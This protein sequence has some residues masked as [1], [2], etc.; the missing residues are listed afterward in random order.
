MPPNTQKRGNIYYFRRKVPVDLRQHYDKPVLLVSLGTPDYATAKVRAAEMTSKTN[1]EFAGLRGRRPDTWTPPARL[2]IP[3]EDIEHNEA[4]QREFAANRDYHG[5]VDASL[6]DA[7]T[8]TNEVLARASLPSVEDLALHEF[9]SEA[10][11]QQAVKGIQE[12][13][14]REVIRMDA[15]DYLKNLR[16]VVPSWIR[17]NSPKHNST[18][19]TEKAIDLFEEAVGVVPLQRLT[20]AN[21]AQFVAFLLDSERRGFGAKTAGNHAACI[22][23]LLNVAVKDDL[24]ERNPLDLTFDKSADA[25]TREPWT[26]A[27]MA[28]M[29][30]HALF[31]DG[32]AAIPMWHKVSPEDGRALLLLLLHTGA[33]IGEIAQLRR[34]D[35]LTRGGIKAIRITAEAGAVKTTDSERVVPL[36]THLL[37]D[38][39]FDAWLSQVVAGGGS[40]S[41]AM[42]SM[43]GRARGPADAATQWFKLFREDAGLPSGRLHGS[44]KFRHWIR[45]TL[46]D[47]G[48]GDATADS[49]TGHAAQ[50]SSGRVV[51]TAS[52]SLPV[53][54][55][56]LDRITY[57]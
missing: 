8:T 14:R 47:K 2:H 26:D 32:M 15:P 17:R 37:S 24:I 31:S 33:R 38:P 7:R 50:G 44:H 39:W 16:H 25:E 41:P 3:V 40:D 51:Y 4:R 5:G 27:E 49:I 45:S 48:V 22:T 29:Y 36:A 43:H 20:K 10:Q 35:F 9:L 1:R 56:A 57:P 34:S 21:G 55:E 11:A 13:T 18:M 52:A 28:R 53:M 46:A 30:G 23:A 42:P 19:R 12:K 54:L 6:R